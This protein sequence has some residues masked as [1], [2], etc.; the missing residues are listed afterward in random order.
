[1]TTPTILLPG[2]SIPSR[3]L[4]S[5]DQSTTLR[6]GSGTRLLY[7]GQKQDIV[8]ATQAGLLSHDAKRNT[9]SVLSFPNRR[10]IPTANDLIIAQI[11]HSSQDYFH[12]I[13]TPH[14]PHALLAQLAFEGATKKTRPMLKAGE[15][16]YA[17]VLSTGV[18]AGTEVELTCVNP[19]TGKA[20]P[21][22]LGQLTGG[23]VFDVS[24]G[25]AAR[26][27]KAGSGSQRDG[28]AAGIAV[29]EELG[30]KLEGKGGF[31]IAVG[32]N[33]RVWVDCS[34]G[35]DYATRITVAVGRCLSILDERDLSV[36]DQKKLVS[37]I[38]REMKIEV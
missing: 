7:Q 1:M 26:L 12:C 4:H 22:G 34:N 21:G 15:L 37:K 9:I 33:G 27:M 35:G 36:S 13:I 19:T 20:E 18:G 11:H 38:L 30:N 25:L 31:E 29:L 28:G 6:L 23:M 2:E 8:V 16:V 17:R 3:V 14:T 10:Y 32:R 24:M 5:N